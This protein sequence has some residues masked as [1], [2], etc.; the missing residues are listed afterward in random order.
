MELNV[1]LLVDEVLYLLFLPG[2][3]LLQEVEK[4]LLFSFAELRG[5]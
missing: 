5:R 3:A 1:K 2:L 4:F